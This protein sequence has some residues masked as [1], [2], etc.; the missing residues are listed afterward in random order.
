MIC[1]YNL[2]AQ[3]WLIAAGLIE[4]VLHQHLG[5]V[6]W[7]DQHDCRAAAHGQAEVARLAV[8]R[9]R[10]FWVCLASRK[11]WVKPGRDGAKRI[12]ELLLVS[13]ACEQSERK[14]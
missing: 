4:R 9:V 7:H 2:L 3:H 10:I 8:E 5:A 1:L 14:A 6:D 13:L 12:R 11:G